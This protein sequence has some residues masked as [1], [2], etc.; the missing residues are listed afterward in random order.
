MQSDT[1]TSHHMIFH[2]RLRKLALERVNGAVSLWKERG[3]RNEEWGMRNKVKR[4]GNGM[5]WNGN[6]PRMD[7]SC[8]HSHIT[9]PSPCLVFAFA[10]VFHLCCLCL[11]TYSFSPHGLWSRSNM[12]PYYAILYYTTHSIFV[13]DSI[14][15]CHAIS[16]HSIPLHSI[17]ILT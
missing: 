14:R 3:A 5:R 6:H 15:L 13:I 12:P 1:I 16:F 10:F 8:Q 9:L 17:H 2:L 4:N 7:R 11:C